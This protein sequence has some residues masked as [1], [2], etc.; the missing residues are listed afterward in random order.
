MNPYLLTAI[1]LGPS[2]F[3]RLVNR[4]D[5]SDLDKEFE[6]D[7]FTVREV[8][9]HLA[10]WEPLF[11]ERME[12]A[13]ASPGSPIVTYDEGERAIELNYAAKDVQAE[14]AL[15]TAERA[16]T[17]AFLKSLAKPDFR[18]EYIHPAFGPKVI[19]DQAN[20]LLG[21]DLYHV[22]QLTAYLDAVGSN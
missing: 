15:Y 5:P 17:V 10:D 14:L 8:I 22:E 6:P 21:H 13:L 11:R 4:F 7:R 16:V 12:L 1:P 18:L 9:A 3:Q 2:I 20:M 19:E